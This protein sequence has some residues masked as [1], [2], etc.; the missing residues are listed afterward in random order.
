[1][2]PAGPAHPVIVIQSTSKTDDAVRVK[3]TGLP[4]A[5]SR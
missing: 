1:M 2:R 5:A 4:R 3:A